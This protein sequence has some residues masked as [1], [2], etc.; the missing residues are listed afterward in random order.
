MPLI[1]RLQMYWL[2]K[3]RCSMQWESISIMMLSLE[4]QGNMLLMTILI[5]YLKPRWQMMISMP[6]WL[7]VCHTKTLASTLN[8]GANVKSTMEHSLTALW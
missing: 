2:Q 4:L 8:T 6:R 5:D 3:M 1:N 7:I